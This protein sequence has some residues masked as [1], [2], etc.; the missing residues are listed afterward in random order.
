M[1]INHADRHPIHAEFA[2]G[3]FSHAR[4]QQQRPPAVSSWWTTAPLAHFTKRAEAEL[5]TRP[6]G[7]IVL[8]DLKGAV[9]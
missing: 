1:S 9:D 8:P 7:S 5:V 6:P 4:K 3:A 2:A